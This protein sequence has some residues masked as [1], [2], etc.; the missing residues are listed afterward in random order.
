MQN[1]REIPAIVLKKKQHVSRLGS[2]GGRTSLPQS[3][4]VMSADIKIKVSIRKFC[5]IV[6]TSGNKQEGE[7][8]RDFVNYFSYR[9]ANVSSSKQ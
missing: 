4:D 5:T 8:P 2:F 7:N 1:M 6:G 9:E 3:D